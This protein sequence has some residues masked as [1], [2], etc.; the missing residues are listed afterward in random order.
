MFTGGI[1]HTTD[2]FDQKIDHIVLFDSV[3]DN[4]IMIL[5]HPPQ[6][7]NVYKNYANQ[8]YRSIVIF[9]I[10][11][12]GKPQ[13]AEILSYP[14]TRVDLTATD[15]RTILYQPTLHTL[16][17]TSISISLHPTYVSSWSAPQTLERSAPL[18]KSSRYSQ[19]SLNQR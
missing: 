9:F 18:A 14:D 4:N 19:I 11:H 5:P 15:Y 10:K 17:Y 2:S 1:I 3:L 13:H 6:K 16:Q 7:M 8:P 12:R